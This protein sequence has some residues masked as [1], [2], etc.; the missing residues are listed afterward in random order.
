MEIPGHSLCV[1]QFSL[2]SPLR[3]LAPLASQTLTFNSETQ[4]HTRFRLGAP[5]ALWPG[6]SLRATSWRQLHVFGTLK[7]RRA[8]VFKA[9]GSHDDALAQQLL[10]GLGDL[11][12]LLRRL[13]AGGGCGQANA[14]DICLLPVA[15]SIGLGS[16]STPRYRHSPARPPAAGHGTH[17]SLQLCFILEP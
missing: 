15:G 9:Q 10:G 16:T 3:P 4:L 2:L 6:N 17:C 11:G 8:A 5:F 1:Q 13:G 14:L 7:E 12:F